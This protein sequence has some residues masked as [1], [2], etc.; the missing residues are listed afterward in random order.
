[1]TQT[2]F[3]SLQYGD[4]QVITGWE[5]GYYCAEILKRERHKR[6]SQSDCTKSVCECWL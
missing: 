5:G 1:V 4:T 2:D 3:E 6:Y